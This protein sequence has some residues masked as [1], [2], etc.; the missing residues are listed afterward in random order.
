MIFSAALA[1]EVQVLG[2]VD[3]AHAAAADPGLDPVAGDDRADARVV[4]R[5]RH[6][7]H[8]YGRRARPG[9]RLLVAGDD[10]ADGRA[11]RVASPRSARGGTALAGTPRT[12]PRAAAAEPPAAVI[13]ARR[14]P[15]RRCATRLDPLGLEGGP[16]V[17][18][19]R[20]RGRGEPLG[21][22]A[23]GR[24]RALV[25]PRALRVRQARAGGAWS[26]PRRW[27]AAASW[28][29]PSSTALRRL[30]QAAELPRRQ[31]A[32][33]HP[34]GRRPRGPARPRRSAS[35]T[36][37]SR[38]IR[39]AA[40]LHDIGKIAIP[41]SIL[42]K[43]GRLTE[44][45]VRGRQDARRARRARAGG[46]QLGRCWRPPRDRPPPPR[47][48]GRRRLPGRPGGRGDPRRGADRR[49]RRRLRRARARA[50]VQGVV[51]A[52]R[53]PP[54]RSARAPARS[55]TPAS[56]RRSSELGPAAWE[57]ETQPA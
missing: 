36:A 24:L 20:R 18:G 33:A 31:H 46:R 1:A 57:M 4:G 6:D 27:R 3:D 42:L 15:S 50:P 17:V 7:A 26:P 37:R 13:A 51:D 44:R 54:R 48:L 32:R 52:S 39:A 43:P 34:A 55:S 29:R 45:G 12:S 41:D 49:G 2:A 8:Q 28:R 11:A 47:A 38:S 35:A 30:L 56:W 25:E 5:V 19:A 9:L 14:Q 40:P 10:L 16:P 53:T 22:T 23:A 21:A